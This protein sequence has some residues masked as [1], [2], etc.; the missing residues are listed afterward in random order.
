MTKTLGKSPFK[1]LWVDSPSPGNYLS[2]AATRFAE[3]S[4]TPVIQMF[5]DVNDLVECSLAMFR[6]VYPSESPFLLWGDT[7]TLPW[8][9]KY[10]NLDGESLYPR[11]IEREVQKILEALGSGADNFSPATLPAQTYLAEGLSS[12]VQLKIQG[13]AVETLLAADTFIDLVMQDE[14]LKAVPWLATTFKFHMETVQHALPLAE[15]SNSARLSAGVAHSE[16]RAM[17]EEVFEWL[18]EN[19]K[20]YKTL[21]QVAHAIAGKVAPIAW[22][23]ARRWVGEWR[24]LRA[25]SSG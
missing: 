5:K 17:K 15:R 2:A 16:N 25:A 10:W 22:R 4:A 20:N 19:R 21:D 8:I 24:K 6:G 12:N 9:K 1:H 18:D 23:T 7:L 14:L 11:H 13:L 3:Q